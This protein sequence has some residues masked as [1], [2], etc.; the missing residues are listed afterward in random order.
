MKRNLFTSGL[1]LASMTFPNASSASSPIELEGEVSIVNPEALKY[2]YMLDFPGLQLK[3]SDP[4]FS[5]LVAGEDFYVYFDNYGAGP[6]TMHV[7]GIGD[8]EGELTAEVNILKGDIT[9]DLYTISLPDANNDTYNGYPH[10][11][12]Y[13][14]YDLYGGI[15]TYTT[16]EIDS[17]GNPAGTPPEGFVLDP[18]TG[19]Y[20]RINDMGEYEIFDPGSSDGVTTTFDNP[21]YPA[22]YEIWLEFPETVNYLAMP[23]TKVGE[24]TIHPVNADQITQLTEMEPGLKKKGFNG[25]SWSTYY[26]ER[27][28]YRYSRHLTFKSG[29]VVSINLDDT[30]TEATDEGDGGTIG[31][32]GGSADFES[33][34]GFEIAYSTQ[35]KGV[36]F[37]AELL[38]I[39]TLERLSLCRDNISSDAAVIASLINADENR[40]RVASRLNT[41]SLNN[42]RITGD[43]SVF[44]QV[45]PSIQTLDLG[46]NRLTEVSTFLSP[47]TS[48]YFSDQR[49]D[50]VIDLD[51]TKADLSSLM[52]QVP[53]LAF[54]DHYYQ[55]ISPY[56]YVT[57]SDSENFNGNFGM[58]MMVNGGIDNP[59]IQRIDQYGRGV[60]RGPL[61]NQLFVSF[62]CIYSASSGIGMKANLKLLPFDLNFDFNVNVADLQSLANYILNHSEYTL[63]NFTSA[64]MN[65]DGKVN[66]V[67]LVRFIN[68]MLSMTPQSFAD[69]DLKRIPSAEGLAETPSAAKLY[70]ENGNLYLETDSDIAA[71]DIAVD[72]G[73]APRWVDSSSLSGL[74]T[75]THSVGNRHRLLAYSADGSVLAAGVHLL[76]TGVAGTP[77]GGSLST[78]EATQI[79]LRFETPTGIENVSAD[80]LGATAREGRIF[81]TS[82][83]KGAWTLTDIS[84]VRIG[85]GSFDEGTTPLP[86]AK[87]DSR[88][89]ILRLATESETLTLKL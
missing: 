2:S 38:E 54:Y 39:E 43:I 67:D 14:S 53:S 28:A 47:N 21:V 48:V 52:T 37:P 5:E 6:T 33:L 8:Y 59:Y 87:P 32:G 76:A 65:S 68:L 74:T 15:L 78:Q 11:A 69:A 30:F 50:R 63:F 49:T 31:G 46:Y 88:P 44:G 72:A 81:V 3:F 13:R 41:L 10:N 19:L 71:I 61:E 18:E 26:D 58:Q 42:N 80:R 29:N 4:R 82:P 62:G 24:M 45:F 83:E 40:K 16:S 55:R 56:I 36:P 64:D 77:S 35:S 57:L 20:Y 85:S 17:S 84:G 86:T 89:V 23:R 79:P 34:D 7:C 73:T 75:T 1:L 22:T 70:L 66:A 25:F 12:T 60:Y 27:N 9:P 51:L